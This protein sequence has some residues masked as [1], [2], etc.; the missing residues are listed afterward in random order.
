MRREQSQL[1]RRVTVRLVVLVMVGAAA[2][3][4]CAPAGAGDTHYACP[5]TISNCT[6]ITGNSI[7]LPGGRTVNEIVAH[8]Q[9]RCPSGIPVGYTYSTGNVGQTQVFVQ[10]FQSYPNTNDV[11]NPVAGPPT[12]FFAIV[13]TG[14]RTT[15]QD[16]IGCAPAPA[17]SLRRGARLRATGRD[18]T[19]TARLDPSQARTPTPATAA[20]PRYE[21][22]PTIA[23]C[24]TVTG[25]WLDVPTGN[26]FQ[27]HDIV[28]RDQ[29]TCPAGLPVG[30]TYSGG[31]KGHP[32]VL[33][34]V[35][36]GTRGP[37][38]NT[39]FFGIVNW[40]PRTTVQLRT[41]CSPAPTAS[42]GGGAPAQSVDRTKTW[43]VR[44]E[45]SQARSYTRGCP[46][47]MR[48]VKSGA[49]VEFSTHRKPSSSQLGA[50]SWQATRY[51][52]TE[53]VR[54]TTTPSLGRSRAALDIFALCAPV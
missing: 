53:T 7:G 41:G 33:A 34:Q 14:E 19:V 35:F 18:Q 29:L 1:R 49:T 32:S 52:N 40:G 10:I 50:V 9:L 12:V 13:H 16:Q 48:L 25:G 38:P 45:P 15:V 20:E 46:S 47:G 23:N 42:A 6:V 8:D 51:G 26:F 28:V 11:W 5:P 4:V 43:T 54:V 3:D 30:F 37:N 36:R 2:L 22:P 21:C 31:N 44:L 17:A 39:V 24:T 27:G